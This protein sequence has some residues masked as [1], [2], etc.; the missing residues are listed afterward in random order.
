MENSR[1]VMD[2]SSPLP[3]DVIQKNWK[4][5]T[6][7]LSVNSDSQSLAC[8]FMV[9]LW[10]VDD[11]AFVCFYLFTNTFFLKGNK[12]FKKAVM[13]HSNKRVINQIQL[14]HYWLLFLQFPL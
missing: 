8:I 9:L 11:D 1:A 7:L 2:R 4:K 12:N 6:F 10:S 3:M 14:Y 13:L 5:K